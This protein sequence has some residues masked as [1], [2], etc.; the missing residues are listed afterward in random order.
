MTQSIDRARAYFDS[1]E[2]SAAEEYQA[3]V[4]ALRRKKGFGLFF[5]QASPEQGQEILRD[6]RQDLA[7][8]HVVEVSLTRSDERLFEQLETVLERE[9]VDIFWVDGLAQSLLGYEDML[10]L[11]GWDEQDLMTY[12]WKDVPPILSHLNLGRERFELRFDFPLVFVVPLF[13]VK[14]LLRRAG[15]FFDWKSGFFEF[16]DDMHSFA[17]QVVQDGD[18]SNYI[19]LDAVERQKKILQ[20]KDCLDTAGIDTD[21]RAKLLREIGRLFYAGQYYEQAILL[22]NQAIEIKQDFLEAWNDRGHVMRKLGRYEEARNSYN[23]ASGINASQKDL[24]LSSTAIYYNSLGNYCYGQ[25][26]YDGAI[27]AYEESIKLD[28]KFIKSYRSL[29]KIY[30]RRK[31]YSA[32]IKIYQRGIDLSRNSNFLLIVVRGESYALARCYD[33]SLQD[34]DQLLMFDPR[35]D[36]VCYFRSL[37][38]TELNRVNAAQSYLQQAIETSKAIYKKDSTN[39]KNNFNLALYHLAAHNTLRSEELYK[40]N[41]DAPVDCIDVAIC[42]LDDFLH[43]F[44]DN[45]QAQKIQQLLQEI[46]DQSQRLILT[47]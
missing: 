46:F 3:L 24:E 11:A 37:V 6:L 23:A 29:G 22:F 14:Y 38:Y 7:Q 17:K 27:K 45:I 34:F 15:D 2:P 35:T 30:K 40:D 25:K 32:A 1:D 39:W 16:P 10:R 33:E 13:V 9:N 36:W 8:K 44:P 26:D 42:D 4:R 20:I 5:V 28:P 19:E 47:K 12:S 21:Q 31:D 41:L 18:Y 43:F